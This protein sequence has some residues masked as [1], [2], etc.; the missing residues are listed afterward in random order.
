[1]FSIKKTCL[2]VLAGTCLLQSSAHADLDAA[3][4]SAIEPYCRPYLREPHFTESDAYSWGEEA[5]KFVTDYCIELGQGNFFKSLKGM[6]TRGYAMSYSLNKI[7]ATGSEAQC[8]AAFVK[9]FASQ[10]E[11]LNIDEFVQKARFADWQ[12]KHVIET[13]EFVRRHVHAEA[14]LQPQDY[15]R[16]ENEHAKEFF[17]F[18]YLKWMAFAHELQLPPTA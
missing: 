1:M 18:F 4:R 5:V 14:L 13:L 6:Y 9:G 8:R 15:A 2:F 11:K 7:L 17:A 10:L 16:Y 3:S 12:V